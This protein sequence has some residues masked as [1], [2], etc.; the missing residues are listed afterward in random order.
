MTTLRQNFIRE[1]VIRGIASRTQESYVGAVYGLAKYYHQPPDQ[2]SDE[3]LKQY[4][5]YLAQEKELAPATLNL[6]V[7]ALRS[8]YQLVLQRSVEQLRRCLPPV[9]QAVH[10]PQVFSVEEMEKLLTAGCVHPKHRAFLM[11]VY[12]A[13]LRL[14]EAC[15]LKP[16]HIDSARMVIRV[17][18]GKGRNYAKVVVMQRWS[19]GYCGKPILSL[20]LVGSGDR[21]KVGEICEKTGCFRFRPDTALLQECVGSS[22]HG[23]QSPWHNSEWLRTG[24]AR[25]RVHARRDTPSRLGS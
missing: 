3:Q 2:L 6:T 12:G 11:T 13:G 1:L 22:P 23:R 10:R 19:S 20:Y 5:F 24:F 16:A 17:E 4:I 8:F 14:N 9:K 15:H 25:A 21:R 7:Y 18:E